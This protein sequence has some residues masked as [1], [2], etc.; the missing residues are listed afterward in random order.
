MSICAADN[1][2]ELP[3]TTGDPVSVTTWPRATEASSVAA[4]GAIGIIS[5]GAGVASRRAADCLAWNLVARPR[6]LCVGTPASRSEPSSSKLLDMNLVPFQ[7][8]KSAPSVAPSPLKVTHRPL[9]V[10][11][12]FG[13]IPGDEIGA[14]N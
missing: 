4:G 13:A 6:P 3:L 8:M 14:I 11:G 1:D 2:G 5:V 9:G 7:A 12:E 10:G